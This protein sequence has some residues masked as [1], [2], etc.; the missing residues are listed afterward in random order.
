[1]RYSKSKMME[2]IIIAL[3]LGL[4]PTFL[5]AEEEIV[6]DQG[7]ESVQ[8]AVE[9]VEGTRARIADDTFD[10]QKV[11]AEVRTVLS[12]VVSS[13]LDGDMAGYLKYL[14]TSDRDR[15]KEQESVTQIQPVSETWMK[16]WEA[17]YQKNLK[18][19]LRQVASMPLKVNSTGVKTAQAVLDSADGRLAF[20][21]DRG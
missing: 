12:S 3:I 15:F 8:S 13:A 2:G 6:D 14:T 4:N 1:M 18:D 11:A 9:T 5:L 21:L 10:N 16:D 20:N 17:Q 7:T 19:T